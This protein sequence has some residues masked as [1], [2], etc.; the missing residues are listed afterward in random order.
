VALGNVARDDQSIGLLVDELAELAPRG[1]AGVIEMDVGR[2]GEF[3]I[4]SLSFHGVSSQPG[5]GS[6]VAF[7][8]NSTFF[9]A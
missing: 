9:A 5:S 7:K 4:V 3:H 8:G 2:P 6:T 1:F